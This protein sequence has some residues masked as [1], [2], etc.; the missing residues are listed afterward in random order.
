MR[1]WWRDIGSAHA[2]AIITGAF[3]I[4]LLVITTVWRMPIGEISYSDISNVANVATSLKSIPPPITHIRTPEPLRAIYITA[5]TASS[6][7]NRERVLSVVTGTEINAMV[8]DIKDYSGTLAYAST[9]IPINYGGGCRII[10][11]PRFIQELHE[12]G[13]YAIARITVFQ[14]P[15]Y[16]NQNPSVAVKNKNNTD[17]VWKDAKG[18]SYIDP[19]APSYWDYI[20]KIGKEAYSIGFD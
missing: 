14:D 20:I 6:R 3:V 4:S 17:I 16:A 12:K 11:L 1:I 5:C 9:S 8:I 18:L 15:V 10:D 13:I 7:K 19:G 2:M